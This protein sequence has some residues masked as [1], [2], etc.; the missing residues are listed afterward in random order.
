MDS[1]KKTVGHEFGTREETGMNPVEIQ[2]SFCSPK[3]TCLQN[4]NGSYVPC[5]NAVCWL[6][7]PCGHRFGGRLIDL[8][9][10]AETV[11]LTL[12]CRTP[13]SKSVCQ[14]AIF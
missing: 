11:F 5:K 6:V 10:V 9:R 4:Q 12:V 3:N 2:D 7:F 14:V 8:S 1:L 13:L